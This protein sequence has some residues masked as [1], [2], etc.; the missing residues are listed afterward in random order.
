MS[1]LLQQIEAMRAQIHELSSGEQTLVA[2]LGE[3][4]I[5]ADQQLLRAVQNLS[6]EH[7]RRRGMIF[8]ELQAL[9]LRMGTLPL[10]QGPIEAPRNDWREPQPAFSSPLPHQMR[11]RS[12]WQ[13]PA[14]VGKDERDY[15]LN[16]SSSMYPSGAAL[17][18]GCA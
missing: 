7:E 9:A 4:L 17:D 18:I 3:A 12:D 2:A 16:G 6:A 5:Q 14:L 15:H 13:Q 11:A 1:T 10:Q 8:R